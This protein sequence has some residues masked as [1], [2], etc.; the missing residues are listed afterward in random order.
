MPEA[1]FAPDSIDT[2]IASRLP[3]WLVRSQPERIRALHQAL[4]R[5][6]VASHS[7]AARLSS[8]PDLA[9]YAAPL[10]MRALSEAGV[11]NAD[12]QAS[13]VTVNHTQI[14]PSPAAT[15]PV[16]RVVSTSTQ[17]LLAAALHNFH[18]SE[19]QPS[20]LR[21]GRLENAQ[22]QR[23]SL[24]LEQ[25]AALCR[26]L[27]LGGGYQALLNT[28]LRPSDQP[29]DA[30]G[31]RRQA[32]ASLF[33]ESFR[34]HLDVAVRLARLK[35]ELDERSYL[36][37]VPIA[38]FNP[39]VPPLA[40]IVR[41]RQL[42]LLGKCMRG[43]VA[44]E[45][46]PTEDAEV[47]A[48]IAWIPGD[49]QG[50]MSRHASWQ[51]LYDMIALRLRGRDYRQFFLRFVSER[52]RPGFFSVLAGLLKT[53]KWGR[54]VE[55]DGRNTQIAIPLFEHLRAQRIDTLLD[56]ARVLAVATD[57][58]DEADRRQRL[59]GYLSGGLDLLGLIGMFVPVLGEVML[60][61]GAVQLVDQVYEGYQDW[62][63]G[64]RQE[65]LGHFFGV[66]ETIALGAVMATGGNALAGAFKRA[67]FVDNLAPS[68]SDSASVMLNERSLSAFRLPALDE[69]FGQKIQVGDRWRLRVQENV[70]TV[71]EDAQ[72]HAWRVT[73][74]N[75]SGTAAPLLEH[76]G[77]GGWRHA[78]ELPQEW[79]GS[80]YLLQRLSSQFA[81]V[82]DAAAD[83]LLLCT[84]FNEEQLRGLHVEGAAAPARLL[85]AFDRYQAHDQHP[86]LQGEAFEQHMQAR[87]KTPNADESVV[88]RDFPGL[89][90]RATREILVSATAQHI[91]ELGRSGRVPLSLAERARWHLYDARLDRACAGLCQ[92]A[93]VNA[94]TRR[95]AVG[96]IERIAPWT[97]VRVEIY[98][99][100]LD[101]TPSLQSSAPATA[102]ARRILATGQ[103]YQLLDGPRAVHALAS[104]SLLRALWLSMDDEQ[105]AQL[106]PADS[107]EL[108]LADLLLHQ[109]SADRAQAAKHIG[110]APV[111]VGV[112][113]PRRLG[114]GRF[115]YPLSGR[116]GNG[117]QACR[118]GIHQIF[119]TM[120]DTQLEHY[121]L[122]LINQHVDLW[123]HY[124]Q[125]QRQLT[126]LRSSL[127]DWRGH[128][129]NPLRALR[130]RRV[131]TALRRCWRRKLVGLDGE[132]ELMIEGEW[133]NTL[134][135]LPTGLSFDHVRRL[136]LRNMDLR[137]I[138]AD[139]L[140]RF[141]NLVELDLADNRLMIVPEGL[142]QL[143]QLRRLDLSRNRIVL[144]PA[145]ER[146]LQALSRLHTL[147]L[148][149]NP[150]LRPPAVEGLRFLR[151]FSL[152]GCNLQDLPHSPQ[153]LPWRSL[154]DYRDN[155]LREVRAELQALGSSLQRMVLHDNPL[156][157]ESR[158][159]LE[160]A[161]G[162]SIPRQ[163][164]A[165]AHQANNDAVL[166][167]WLGNDTSNRRA[168]R[169]S[170]WNRL[171]S[172]AGSADLFR[173]L[174]D[175]TRTEEFG[176]STWDYRDRVWHILE[177]CEQHESL[178]WFVFNETG[179]AR[180]CEDRLL[181][182]LSQLEVGMLGH[183]V[184]VEQAD[185]QVERRL[186][187]LGRG[188]Y[189][190][191]EVDRIAA[192]HTQALHEADRQAMA[193]L[194]GAQAGQSP[195]TLVDE[196][197]TRLFYRVRLARRLG[198][199]EQPRRM[200]Y[201][202]SARVTVGDIDN[203]EREILQAESVQA[204]V[205]SLAER[206]FW[207]GH[208]QQRHSADFAALADPFH[209][210]LEGAQALS[211]AGTISEEQYLQRAN[212]LMLALQ[213]AERQ[214]R[215]SLAETACQRWL[216]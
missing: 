177:A 116:P 80:T 134:P 49:P 112:R 30:P 91:T 24:S 192:A 25:F 197:E 168:R 127:R 166:A 153:E 36:Q 11:A 75:R 171:S 206:P 145:G 149:Y 186:V 57:E 159:A 115:G 201:P 3:A 18:L 12:V 58:E 126:L 102:S 128:W 79:Q 4:H 121:L 114:D 76:N 184:V 200:H 176:Y 187:E 194:E 46:R 107:G 105:L 26:R 161:R 125:L 32:L 10:L 8:I 52:D 163:G 35:D 216:Q 191:D 124:S 190:L 205:D 207:D 139:F 1:I 135:E 182:I 41:P 196:I 142:E 82:S 9:A 60:A 23:L 189:R 73:H 39:I 211:S 158:V 175:F 154:V 61:V 106:S 146:R 56:D 130:R 74:P 138:D 85:D 183:Q 215:H 71:S 90:L 78:F 141:P 118:R 94:D 100:G 131:A 99:G 143:R 45:A 213:A 70:Y 43:I 17:S 65:A 167:E 157:E 180:T 174:A 110:M 188:L 137:E 64:D 68:V 84:G 62:R 104:D 95:L 37:M 156:N 98:D 20:L 21:Q 209:A 195:S 54:T 83:D 120:T 178:R 101:R 198:L 87:E 179:G 22:G 144:D 33:E 77:S 66:A 111:G 214:L 148:S 92:R 181:L 2:L 51:A 29:A 34:A 208:V 132:Y 129:S 123:Q 147:N 203:A 151:L 133:I 109:A 172:E 162:A 97:D 170:L 202:G 67:A 96:L 6:Q 93:A 5:Q 89:S 160:A 103:G 155:R 19:T 47:E 72:E 15:L 210:Q 150:L 69:P 122:P 28:Q 119:P 113:L 193:R 165:R 204:V 38:S 31:E 117:R 81:A 136:S 164:I 108:Q 63:L 13:H 50:E 212:N 169:T 152:R 48:V 88:M 173:F 140:G 59:Q 42:Y 55:L 27:D 16:Q 7:L 86:E 199:P 44:V 53:S 14:V 185:A 40:G